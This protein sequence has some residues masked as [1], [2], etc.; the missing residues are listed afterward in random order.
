MLSQT[1]YDGLHAK[2]AICQASAQ[3]LSANQ[4][5]GAAV[6]QDVRGNEL[7]PLL[8]LLLSNPK[9]VLL[10][11]NKH[12]VGIF[13][14]TLVDGVNPDSPVSFKVVTHLNKGATKSQIT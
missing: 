8:S 12:F 2:V 9:V 13:K 14:P 1:A 6:V 11:R 5:Q 10:W 3:F 4:T 7:T